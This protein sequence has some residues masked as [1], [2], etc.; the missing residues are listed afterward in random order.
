[1]L[2][3]LAIL[4]ISNSVW[5][6]E[7]HSEMIHYLKNQ[8]DHAVYCAEYELTKLPEAVVSVKGMSSKKNRIMLNTIGEISSLYP[9]RYLEVGSRNGST[10]IS[11]MYGNRFTQ[12]FA[13]EEW[14][15]QSALFKEFK[16]NCSKFLFSQFTYI[17]REWHRPST[18]NK[19][20][21][22]KFDI[23]LYDGSH[24][25]ETQYNAW[26]FIDLV[27]SDV[28]I[29]IVPDWASANTRT[30]TEK[31][32]EDLE[33]QVIKKIEIKPNLKNTKGLWNGVMVALIKK[34]QVISEVVED[35]DLK[36]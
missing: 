1:M 7:G 8:I 3:Y 30:A 28:F 29:A 12:A 23:Y 9:A 22:Q 26:K 2:K 5:G 21:G 33:Y 19:L 18:L 11:T 6:F 15:L 34:K 13:I 35:Q 31:A 20:N 16:E 24:A 14:S 4:L 17:D 32:F 25:P 10:F 36:G 27:L